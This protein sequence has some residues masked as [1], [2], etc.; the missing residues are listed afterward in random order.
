MIFVLIKD[1]LVEHCIAVN[2]IE[3]LVEFYPEHLILEQVGEE[4][5]GWAYDGVTFTPPQE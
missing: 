5:V 3:D 2:G 1:G 4:N